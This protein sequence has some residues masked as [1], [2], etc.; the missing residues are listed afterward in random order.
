L[1]DSKDEVQIAHVTI[2]FRDADDGPDVAKHNALEQHVGS[3][4]SAG[5]VIGTAR[6]RN[7][8]FDPR[9]DTSQAQFLRELRQHRS[10]HWL[11]GQERHFA[12]RRPLRRLRLCE[13]FHEMQR[14][15][16]EASSSAK[17]QLPLATGAG[18]A[19]LTQP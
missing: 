8:R 4:L 17:L 19:T 11:D 9:L 10:I 7:L 6:L 3:E 2:G 14:K 13:L 5:R 12:N 1:G 16:A 18:N 15:S